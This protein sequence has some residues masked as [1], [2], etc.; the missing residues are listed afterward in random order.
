MKW[1]WRRGRKSARAASL[2][3]PIVMT[4]LVSDIHVFWPPQHDGAT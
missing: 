4:A 2:A 1:N 3:R